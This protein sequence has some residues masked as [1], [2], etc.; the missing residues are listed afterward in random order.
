VTPYTV[1]G[2]RPLA[3]SDV[4]PEVDREPSAD[5]AYARALAMAWRLKRLLRV[6][7]HGRVSPGV[8]F[9]SEVRIVDEKG[10]DVK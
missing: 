7:Q 3:P 6:N 9:Y 1:I 5:L 4:L 2:V 8:F 10:E